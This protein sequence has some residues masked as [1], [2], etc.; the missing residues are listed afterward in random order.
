[1]VFKFKNLCI[2][3]NSALNPTEYFKTL[4]RDFLFY[5]QR[6]QRR[7]PAGPDDLTRTVFLPAGTGFYVAK[8]EPIYFKCGVM[9]KA[10]RPIVYDIFATVYYTEVM[11]TE[12]RPQPL[13]QSFELG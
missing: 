7:E 8:D 3:R 13:E 11:S 2:S 5:L 4:K 1:V 10:G 9:N 6:D 12:H